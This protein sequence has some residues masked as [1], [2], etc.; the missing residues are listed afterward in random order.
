MILAAGEGRRMRPLTNQTP[1]PLLPLGGEPLLGRSIRWLDRFGFKRIVVNAHHH[2]DQIEAFVAKTKCRAE[3][4]ISRESEL[5]GTGGGIRHA[6]A[7]WLGDGAWIINGDVVCDVDFN[8][9]SIPQADAIMVLRPDARARELGPIFLDSTATRVVGML[10]HGHTQSTP[11][12]FTGIHYISR[13]LA[14]SLPEPSCVI[15]QGYVHWL[16]LR[17]V[18]AHIHS[19]YWNEIGTPDAYAAVADDYKSGKLHWL[20]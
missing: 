5:L 16:Q 18:A 11:L 13:Q 20:Q 6:A 4:V 2:G 8:K 15:R 1:K 19:G 10:A 7:Y 17:H 3:L 14:E 12:M 9:M